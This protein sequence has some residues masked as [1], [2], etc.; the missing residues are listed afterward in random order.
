MQSFGIPWKYCKLYARPKDKKV[1]WTVKSKHLV[2]KAA[3]IICR[4]KLWNNPAFFRTL[5]VC[6]ER[7][8]F[9]TLNIETCHIEW[10]G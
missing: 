8:G 3:D 6:A 5:K 4:K 7:E 9:K 10:G 2:G 1:T